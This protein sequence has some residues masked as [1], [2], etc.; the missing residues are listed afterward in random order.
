MSTA[1][2]QA[3]EEFTPPFL[4]GHQRKKS[5]DYQKQRQK[6]THTERMR[7]TDVTHGFG[8]IDRFTRG[9]RG[10]LRS[11]F[12]KHTISNLAERLCGAMRIEGDFV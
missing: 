6:H 5:W 8:N 4:H 7:R 3:L 11:R 9:G 12:G 1:P 10:Q 2:D